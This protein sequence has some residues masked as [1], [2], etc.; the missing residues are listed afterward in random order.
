MK[1]HTEYLTI[2]HPEKTGFVHLT[3]QVAEA[4]R[5]LA[6]SGATPLGTRMMREHLAIK[7]VGASVSASGT[8]LGS[9]EIELGESSCQGDSGGPAISERSGRRH[10]GA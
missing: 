10:T 9:H 7:A 2:N 3:P 6:C 8:P 4:V 1:A 5:N